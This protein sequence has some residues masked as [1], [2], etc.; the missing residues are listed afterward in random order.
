MRLLL[1][2]F[3]LQNLR[4]ASLVCCNNVA[5]VKKKVKVWKG[6]IRQ[7]FCKTRRNNKINWEKNTIQQ[8]Q[9]SGFPI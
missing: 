7:L 8:N 3:C 1:R 4:K 6:S 9:N 2:S 5:S